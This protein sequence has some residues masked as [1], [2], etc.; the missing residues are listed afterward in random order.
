MKSM[1]SSPTRALICCSTWAAAAGLARSRTYWWRDGRGRPA[2]GPDHP[3][4]VGA[5]QVGVEVDH[6]GLEPQPELHPVPLDVLDQRSETV[7]PRVG[8]HHPVAQPAAVVTAAA[9]PPVVEDEPPDPDPCGGVGELLQPVEVVVEVDRLPGVQHQRP[10]VVAVCRRGAL[11]AVQPAREPVEAVGGV[12]EHDVR[13][14]VGLP[15]REPHLAGL[16]QLT[17][18]EHG[19]VD[20]GTFG[21]SF[22]EVLVVAA[23]R[24]VD[25]PDLAG[26]KPEAWGADG[27]QEGGV[28]T[29][30]AP[31]GRAQ[32][33]AVLEDRALR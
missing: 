7:R 12:D 28:V 30:A 16:E 6:L 22:G 25:R 11:A 26:A 9:E 10:R 3:V 31:A 19:G 20:A 24:D 13:R 21:E 17:T 8:R 2:C 23:P 14:G 5:H 27:Q 33:R 4:G 18:T 15:R 1:P 29:G 32:V